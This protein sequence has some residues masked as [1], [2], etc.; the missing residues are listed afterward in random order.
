MENMFTI[1]KLENMKEQKAGDN[2]SNLYITIVNI[3]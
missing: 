2:N 3:C 1:E